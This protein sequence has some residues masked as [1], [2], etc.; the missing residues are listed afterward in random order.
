MIEILCLFA[1]H[2]DAAGVVTPLNTRGF[3]GEHNLVG[4]SFG[5]Y[6]VIRSLLRN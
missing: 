1:N 3:V 6:V 4:S 2:L 5:V